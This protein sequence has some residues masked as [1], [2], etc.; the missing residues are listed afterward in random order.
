MSPSLAASDGHAARDGDARPRGHVR[1]AEDRVRCLE[2]AGELLNASL[3]YETTIARVLELL[4]EAEADWAAFSV[5]ESA[6][7]EFVR[8]VAIHHRD[9][10]RQELADR[11]GARYP[12]RPDCCV[13]IA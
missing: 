4:T 13:G 10:A 3:D 5:L 1:T 12:M 6:D 9:P 7:A 8:T 11:I 2:R